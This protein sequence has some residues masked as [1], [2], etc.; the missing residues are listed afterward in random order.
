MQFLVASGKFSL[1]VRMKLIVHLCRSMLNCAQS[2]DIRCFR[3]RKLFQK[4]CSIDNIVCALCSRRQADTE[5]TSLD[6]GH[7]TVVFTVRLHVMQCTALP[8]LFCPSV[9]LTNACNL[10]KRKKRVLIFL[11][12]MKH[13]SFYFS[14]MTYG[15]WEITPPRL[16][17]ILDHTD[18]VGAKTPI[19]DRYS[20][21]A[22]L[23]YTY[24]KTVQLTLIGSPQR[25]FK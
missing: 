1:P 22:P 12:H 18:P 8:R 16:P 4:Y 2:K 25:A 3:T 19:I 7:L 21:V 24:N 11:Y 17:K 20:L 5:L 14:D 13:Y 6:H 15:S 10:R 23:P 9:C